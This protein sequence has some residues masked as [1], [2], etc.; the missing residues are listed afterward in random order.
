MSAKVFFEETIIY[1]SNPHPNIEILKANFKPPYITNQ[2]IDIGLWGYGDCSCEIRTVLK[3]NSYGFSKDEFLKRSLN[4]VFGI[5]NTRKMG[6]YDTYILSKYLL[7]ANKPC[8][9]KNLK[10]ILQLASLYIS[11]NEVNIE[12]IEWTIDYNEEN[13]DFWTYVDKTQSHKPLSE[14]WQLYIIERLYIDMFAHLFDFSISDILTIE[15]VFDDGNQRLIY[16]DTQSSHYSI[17]MFT[18]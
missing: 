8:T 15:T 13:I 1:H 6:K 4:S 10:D 17:N 3:T 12:D 9:C 7:K 18:S 14:Q 5:I 11:C 16:F 2:N